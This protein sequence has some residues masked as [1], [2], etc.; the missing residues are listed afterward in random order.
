MFLRQ[1]LRG[2]RV[3]RQRVNITA[4]QF[5]GGSIDH[6]VPFYRSPPLECSGGNRDVEM[7][8]FASTRMAGMLGAVVTDLEQRRMQCVLERGAQPLDARGGIHGVGPFLNRSR[9][10]QK[11]MPNVKTRTTGK[12]IQTLKVTQADSLMVSATQMFAV[13]SAR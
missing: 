10:N 12:L 8:T 13:P 11:I 5:S 3:D 2:A 6:P 7:A 9:S 4:H 1:D